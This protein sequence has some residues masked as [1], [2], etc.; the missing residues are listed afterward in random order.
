MEYPDHRELGGNATCAC[1]VEAIPSVIGLEGGN[2]IQGNNQENMDT[3]ES[4]ALSP[5]A[6]PLVTRF[7]K[8]ANPKA[9][10]DLVEGDYNQEL[11]S[12]RLQGNAV[13][14]GL[15]I[16]LLLQFQKTTPTN[17]PPAWM[18]K[19]LLSLGADVMQTRLAFLTALASK[20]THKEK[21]GQV[22]TTHPGLTNSKLKRKLPSAAGEESTKRLQR[23]K[24]SSPQ[25]QKRW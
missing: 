7:S 17:Q 13:K 1:E 25:P 20:P 18:P 11:L 4:G 16:T 19:E 21:K 23:K 15:A 22:M 10:L 24:R 14:E 5:G 3:L 9:M 8:S 12:S 2:T 6:D